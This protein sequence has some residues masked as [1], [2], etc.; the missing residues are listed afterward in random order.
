M[1]IGPIL[2]EN[3]YALAALALLPVIW[4]LLRFTPPR[5]DR[6]SFP[7]IRLLLGL[8][9]RDETP[10]KSPW[11]LTALRTLIATAVIV[12]LAEPLYNPDRHVRATSG[13][14]LVIV[15][16][17]WA[18]APSWKLRA[19]TLGS[20]VTAAE[21]S[22]RPVALALTAPRSTPRT[23]AY[24]APDDVRKRIGGLA[25]QALAPARLALADEIAGQ[26]ADPRPAEI[27]WLSDGLDYGSADA[28]AARLAEIAAPGA[29][30]RVIA[31]ERSRSP[32]VL[33]GPAPAEGGLGVRV[34]RADPAAGS[35]GSVRALA[36]NGRPLGDARFSIVEGEN[37][38]TAEF[39]IP[40]ALRN[41]I[42]RLEILGE[43][44]AGGVFLLDDRWR[45]RPV[46]MVSGT[47]R[48][49]AQPL[50]SPLHYVARALEPFAEITEAPSSAQSSGIVSLLDQGQS[51]LI[52]ADIGLLAPEDEARV[53]EWVEDGGILLRFAGPKLAAN[54][55]DLIPVRLRRGG[56]ALGGALSWSQPQTLAPFDDDSPFKGLESLSADVTVSRQ[57]LAE[58]STDL[59]RKTWAR[60]DDGTPLVTAEPRGNGMLV[61]FHVPA[62]P[63]WSNLPLSGV[64]VQML[65]RIVDLS[66]AAVG[67]K[68]DGATKVSGSA[69]ALPPLRVL[70]GFGE[71]VSPPADAVPLP[72]NAD[73]DPAPTPRNP[74]G[75]YGRD[76][77]MRAVNT[78]SADATLAPLHDTAVG[79][80][81]AAYQTEPAT[82]LKGPL[83]A[84]AFILLL[85]DTIAVLILSGRLSARGLT[86]STAA[87]LILLLVG[88]LPG[89]TPRAAAQ[90]S[91]AED[92]F[93]LRAALETRLA[94][95]VTGSV[96]VD[97]VSLAGLTGL[98]GVLGQRT[99][100]EPGAPM[101]VDV[102]RDE[103]AF[104][105][106]IYWP[107]LP[108]AAQPS[109]KALAKIDAYM[110]NG[111]TI[112]FD[113]RDQ[114][115]ALPGLRADEVGPGTAALR[116]ILANLDIPRLEI[117]PE[118]HVI[119]KAFY[120]LQTFPGRWTGGQLWVEAGAGEERQ[121]GT[122]NFDGVSA[123]IIGSNDFA[124]AWAIDNQDK[125][126]LP[127]VPG[128]PRQREMAFRTGI[129]I[130]MYAL[131]G[132]YKA[133]QVHVPALLERLGQ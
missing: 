105:P 82:V 83:L 41:Q 19:D 95:V 110:K 77:R 106:L 49:L 55:D 48:E 32:L 1:N 21:R 50:L 123:V 23:L 4:W 103:L 18:A 87:V 43:R 114:Q 74:P 85:L 81:I 91:A 31:E 117:V 5:P 132:N 35:S 126:L 128:G 51:V 40:L 62:S 121:P 26:L 3:P 68:A 75:L 118:D 10:H 98:S 56:R 54:N 107:V 27:V 13:P 104:F 34:R 36:M 108:E 61:L 93:A 52:I 124:G 111:G 127:V 71:F 6:I 100:L 92:D 116:R 84:M 39:D 125:P 66:A 58:P 70:N 119:T 80:G 22:A 64:F 96:Q 15:D 122:T 130:V 16:D 53:A 46:G 109:D 9:D 57:V 28:F 25:P 131:T 113:T 59:A 14:L 29:P 24:L 97:D 99:A 78:V 102:E 120:L 112:L 79:A 88:A 72:A 67:A 17:G 69:A 89:W 2:F 20:I 76:N 129:N 11:W 133:D 33:D 63:D 8:A 101:G 37:H 30:I 65:R 38:A 60:L 44:S 73:A 42:G 86:R 90:T 94:Y 115:Q 7:P 12:A 45:R 47:S